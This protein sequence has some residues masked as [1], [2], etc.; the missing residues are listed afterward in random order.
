MKYL[1]IFFLF[2]IALSGSGCYYDKAEL[3]NPVTSCDTAI[4]TYSGAVN[5]LLNANCTGCHSGVNAPN[6]VKLDTYPG[7][8]IQ[9]ANGLLLGTIT[10]TPGFSAMPKNGNKLNDCSIA[11]IRKWIAGGAPNN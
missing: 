5:P 7:V 9:A 10:H 3:L 8:K 6:G 4:V 11:K 1:V 2:L